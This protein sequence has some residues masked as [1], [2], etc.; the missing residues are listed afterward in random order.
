MKKKL[1]KMFVNSRHLFRLAARRVG[2]SSYQVHSITLPEQKLIYIPIPKNACS[3]I[4]HSLYYLEYGKAYDYPEYRELGYQ[5]IHAFYEKQKDAFTG[6]HALKN[7]ESAFRFAVIRDPV[8][9]FLSCYSN[10]VIELKDLKESEDSLKKNGL[11]VKPNIKTFI[12]NLDRYRS[13][14]HSIRHHTQPQ[15]I[16][17]DGTIGYLDKI[18]PIEQ[19]NELTAK[20]KNFDPS[21]LM[22]TEKSGGP[23]TKLCDM[24]RESLERLLKFYQDDYE[25]LSD[26][27]SKEDVIRSYES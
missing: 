18:Y 1:H 12:L 16:F 9:R 6:V 10:R 4:K 8:D 5:N 22:K 17:L 11:P 14:N 20:L 26:F 25:L 13:L 19:M 15:S 2:L 23:K 24:N 3:S 21:L 27:Y 7:M